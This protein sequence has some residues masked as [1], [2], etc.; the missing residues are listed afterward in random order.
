MII[1]IDIL[2]MCIA[3]LPKINIISVGEN[4][5]GIRLED[6]LIAI[7]IFFE[8]ISIIKNNKKSSCK[9]LNKIT[10]MFFVYIILCLC[11]TIFGIS[12]GWITTITSFLYLVRKI[13]Y[14]CMIYIGYNYMKRIKD[15]KYLLPKLN[16][17]VYIHF[18]FTIF[19][20]T[21]YNGIF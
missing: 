7:Y 10:R 2:L 21:R 4:T 15:I 18:I 17:I 20:M 16:F 11:S 1:Y 19:Q 12:K 8:V 9:K 14:F 13:E 6:I 5:T 3:I